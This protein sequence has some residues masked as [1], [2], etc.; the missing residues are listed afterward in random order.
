[1][2]VPQQPSRTP[3]RKLIDDAPAEVA[4]AA[5]VMIF[6]QLLK[7]AIRRS[8][9][10]HPYRDSVDRYLYPLSGGKE[11]EGLPLSFVEDHFPSL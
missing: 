9:G 4:A 7:I 11:F 6:V 2:Q 10:I 3:R 5:K 8:D 1:M